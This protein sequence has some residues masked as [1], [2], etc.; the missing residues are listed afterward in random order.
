MRT[1]NSRIIDS[2]SRASLLA[3]EMEDAALRY[4]QMTDQIDS[5]LSADR[6]RRRDAWTHGRKGSESPGPA[7]TPARM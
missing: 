1:P 6:L 5:V 2:P 3:R 4:A 7:P